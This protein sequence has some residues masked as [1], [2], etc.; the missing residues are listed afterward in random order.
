M[1]KLHACGMVAICIG[2]RYQASVYW[3]IIREQ[4]VTGRAMFF[5]VDESGQTGLNLFD[6]T[7]PI[8]YYGVLSS[9]FDLNERARKKVEAIRKK[10]GVDRLHAAEL[11]VGRLT[12]IASSLSALQKDCSISFDI[13]RINKPDHAIISFFDQIF[14]QGINPA[15]PWT[16]YWTPLRYLLLSKV[17]YIFDKDTARLAWEARIERNS[18]RS[19]EILI[20]VINVLLGRLEWLRDARSRE[21]VGDALRWARKNPAEIHYNVYDKKDSL[22]I[23]PNLIGFQSVLHGIASRLKRTGQGASS[24]IV[25]RQSQFNQAQE[26]ITEIYQKGKD[27]PMSIGPGLPVMDLTHIPDIPIT[28]TAGTD[29]VGLEL[30]DVYLWVFKRFFEGKELGGPLYGVISKQFNIGYTDEVSLEGIFKRWSK[31]FAAMPEPTEEEMDRAKQFRVM[32]EER[33]KPHLVNL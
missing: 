12:K 24:I 6:E 20:S 14:D 18:K 32:Q 13:Y 15:V 27:A 23:S 5:Y 10:F 2:M 17:A 8:L 4:R 16:A 33:R 30:V 11:G 9:P 1:A 29:N 21:V 19:E 28:C 7:Q 31:V 26:W 25:D 3:G 22:Q